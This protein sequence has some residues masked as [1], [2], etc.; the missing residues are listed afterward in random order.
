M[1]RSNTALDEEACSAVMRRYQPRSKRE[2]VNFALR[3]AAAEGPG[4]GQ[5]RKMRGSGWK[6]DLEAMRT[7]RGQASKRG[8]LDGP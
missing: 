5:A 3:M 1:A 6:G 4:L 8:N 7:H 2:A